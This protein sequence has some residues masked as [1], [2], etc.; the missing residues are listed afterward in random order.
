MGY[1]AF[2]LAVY[3]S[4]F[5]NYS[6]IFRGYL[7]LCYILYITTM[8]SMQLLRFSTLSIVLFRILDFGSFRYNLLSWSQLIELVPISGHQHQHKIGHINEACC[9]LEIM[10]GS[11]DWAQQSMF[12]PKMETESVLRNVASF[13]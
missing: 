9:C 1:N 10:T 2:R 3:P 6:A 5:G 11:V 7:L 12:H 8:L 13:K 4:R